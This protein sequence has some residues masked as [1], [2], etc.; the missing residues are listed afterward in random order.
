MTQ[1]VPTYET[2]PGGS[3]DY[4]YYQKKAH[5]IRSDDA[6]RYAHA[7]WHWL[8]SLR[9]GRRLTVNIRAAGSRRRPAAI[10]SK[11]GNFAYS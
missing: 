9:P 6:H 7:V 11:G 3:I 4:A 8:K 10:G 2:L 5:A 1:Q